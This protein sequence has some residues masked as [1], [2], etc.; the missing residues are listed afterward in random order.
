MRFMDIWKSIDWKAFAPALI[1]VLNTFIWYTLTY[2]VFSST[3]DAL[4]ISN[5]NRLLLYALYF[6]G[7]TVSAIAGALFLRKKREMGLLLWMLFGALMTFMLGLIPN[8]GFTTNGLICFL[9]GA[10]LGIGF[11]SCL[12]YFAGVTAVEAR[13][14]S[15]GIA[16]GIVGAGTL[17]FAAI[18]S[19][20][21]VLSTFLGLALWR[22]LGFLIF[23]VALKGTIRSPQASPPFAY[24][25]VFRKKD[26]LLYLTPW[27]MLSVVNFIEDPVVT[28]NLLGSSGAIIKLIEFSL[29]GLFAFIGGVFADLFGRKRVIITGFIMLGVGYA[30]LSFS[31]SLLPAFLYVYVVCDGIAW[32]MFSSVFLI[33]LWGDLAQ[34]RKKE[35]YYVIGGL[36]FLLAGFLSVIV[37]P[38]ASSIG[39]S[40]SFSL[41]SFFLFAAVL[42]LI[43]APET[44]PEKR[45]KEIELKEY[46][47][48][49]KRVKDKYV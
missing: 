12:A 11:P 27:I 17:V 5:S 28:T 6:V 49:A 38:Y 47:E 15:G 20:L 7:T 40:E 45:M 1:I 44:L 19:S 41:A 37:G 10:S 31:L 42:P 36:P 33:T 24:T 16:W 48:K 21:S 8:S 22:V 18:I 34:D 29:I 26:L 35:R 4:Q 39:T 3:I 32:G 43:Y 30:V 13:G 14:T 23:Y 2:L 46:L 25:S 9:F